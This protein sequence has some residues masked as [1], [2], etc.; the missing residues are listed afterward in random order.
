MRPRVSLPSCLDAVRATRCSATER[1]DDV[2]RLDIAARCHVGGQSSRPDGQ[3]AGMNL[4][5]DESGARGISSSCLRCVTLRQHSDGPFYFRSENW[6]VVTLSRLP[7]PTL[8]LSRSFTQHEAEAHSHHLTQPSRLSTGRCSLRVK[9][10]PSFYIPKVLPRGPL[11]L[12]D[13]YSKHKDR[14]PCRTTNAS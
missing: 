11:L 9:Y 14:P 10:F 7:R 5:V 12:T 1:R 4:V 2:T 3:R 8:N 13:L 6:P